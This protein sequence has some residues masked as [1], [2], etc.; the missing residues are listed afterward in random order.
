MAILSSPCF[1]WHNLHRRKIMRSAITFTIVFL[2]TLYLLCQR[3]GANADLLRQSYR[4]AQRCTIVQRRARGSLCHRGFP[5]CRSDGILYLQFF[6]HRA[7][8]LQQ[9]QPELL[10]ESRGQWPE[11]PQNQNS[12]L[13][14]RSAAWKP[15]IRSGR[16]KHRLLGGN[17]PL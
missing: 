17:L 10:V 11:R 16:D 9:I 7:G 15:Y 13:S 8:H 5:T 4:L 6:Q 12:Q 14:S 2:W 3:S 1:L